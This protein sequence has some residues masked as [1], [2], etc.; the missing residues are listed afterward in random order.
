MGI[1]GRLGSK[2]SSRSLQLDELCTFFADVISS[3]SLTLTPILLRSADLRD[4]PQC[5]R[6]KTCRDDVIKVIIMAAVPLSLS[7]KA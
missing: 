2:F 6:E 5:T 3:S 7:V 1:R 4:P